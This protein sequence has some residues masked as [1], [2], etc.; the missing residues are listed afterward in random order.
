[1]KNQILNLA[2]CLMVLTS[3]SKSDNPIIPIDPPLVVIT[4]PAP[5]VGDDVVTTFAPN[6]LN[7]AWT[8]LSE[9]VVTTPTNIAP[10]T[11]TDVLKVDSDFIENAI[12]YKIMK[13]TPTNPAGF[14][15]NMVNNNKLRIDGSSVKMTGNITINVGANP[16]TF[17][18]TDFVIFKE[19]AV[20]GTE[21]G[22]V[23]K[24]FSTT[25]PV[26]ATTLPV[27]G[28]YII[29]SVAD[30]NLPT[31]AV[32]GVSYNDV[33]KTIITI[34]LTGNLISGTLSLPALL[35][36]DVIVSTQYYA[37]NI[38]VIK[39]ETVVKYEFA[40]TVASQLPANI[41]PTGLQNVTEKLVSKNF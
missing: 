6:I 40:S 9:T 14:Y 28:T 19:N 31:L 32:G 29:K 33:K 4:P 15:C 16:I 37:K 38:G 1:M 36:Q 18:V 39:A 34:N 24:P 10:T 27:E 21:V 35:A 5:T 23:S 22:R 13:T 3:C 8:F 25:I 26:G 7:H 11:S 41:S 12:A 17:A 2:C 20:S 30:G